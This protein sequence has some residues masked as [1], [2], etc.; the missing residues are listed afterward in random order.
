MKT[1][2]RFILIGLAL[3]FSFSCEQPVGL[4]SR[5]DIEGPVVTI[6]SPAPRKAVQPQFSI[7]GNVSDKTGISRLLI[8]ATLNNEPFQKQ[9]EYKAG[10]WVYSNDGGANKLPLEGAEWEGTGRS[11]SWRVPVDM[12]IE[13]QSLQSGEYTFAV[14]AWDSV[15][16]TDDNSFKTIVLILDYEPPAIDVSN[17]YLYRGDKAYEVSP[18]AELHN[19]CAVAPIVF[20]PTS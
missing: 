10:S 3:I 13:G 16:V 20:C 15:N 12:S 2:K 4:G 5:L 19:I 7:S 14:Q 8:T 9:W 11:V 1:L 6:T 18:L 17:P